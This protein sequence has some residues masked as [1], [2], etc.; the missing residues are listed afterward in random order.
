MNNFIYVVLLKNNHYFIHHT[1]EKP[2]NEVLLEFEI[3]YDFVKT[4]EP[5]CVIESIME[6]NEIH[7]DSIVKDYM[8]NYGYA[9]VRG[10][11]YS[12]IILT[13]DQETFILRELTE[14]N[15]ENVH[16]ISYE[17]I[18]N[19]YINRQWNSIE[20]IDEEYKKV[21]AEYEKYQQ[22]LL[23][24]NE[25]ENVNGR[26]INYNIDFELE[27]LYNFCKSRD[28]D[29]TKV[30]DE[31]IE[32]YKK[33]LPQ[34]KHI[35]KKYSEKCENVPRQYL[36]YMNPFP[37]FYLDPFFYKYSFAP[38]PI[39]IDKLDAFFEAIRYFTNWILCR[40]QELNFDVNSYCYD[41]EWLYPRIFYIL[42]KIKT[43]Y[44]L[45]NKLYGICSSSTLDTS[46]S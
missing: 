22:D 21:V 10:G 2:D 16:S 35:I 38:S 6:K 24:R 19:N 18:L 8:Y 44:V 23:L 39:R 41:I 27:K 26:K 7:L 34:I 20:K 36:D 5:M 17:Y 43:N 15:R 3:Y 40:V 25:I 4:H 37:H 33:I 14:S 31:Y 46:S 9:Y 1:S 32:L 12:N 30:T 11:S 28:N 13:Q 42:E 29:Y 45:V